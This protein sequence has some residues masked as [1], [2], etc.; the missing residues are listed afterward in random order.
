M[1]QVIQYQVNIRPSVLQ[2][3]VAKGSPRP[4]GGHVTPRGRRVLAMLALIPLVL[5]M[6]LSGSHRASAT[7]NAPTT[8]QI[9]VHSGESLWEIAVAVNPEQ[10][11]RKT[12][13][14]IQQLNH[15]S[16]SRLDAGQALLVPAH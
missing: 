13:W 11:P 10:D 12:M 1:T 2:Q 9:V 3:S 8:Q 16:T 5:V 14:Q 15:M 4:V 6:V 7:G